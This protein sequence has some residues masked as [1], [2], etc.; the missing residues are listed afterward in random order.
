MDII[1]CVKHVPETVEEDI[2]IADDQKGIQTM[3]L[4]FDINEWDDYAIEEAVLM[5]EKLGGS[6]T[7]LTVGSEEA[8]VTLRKC[9]AKGADKAIRLTDKAFEGSDAY[10][11]AKILSKAIENLPY[12]LILTGT[13]SS[14]DGYGQVGAIL[15]TLLGIP[16]TTLARKIDVQ[17]GFAIVNRELE[18][19]LEQ[20]LEIKL[21]SVIAVQT[22][23]N[24]PRYVSIMAIRKAREKEIR[25]MGLKDLGLKEEDV[26]KIGSWLNIEEMF[27][28]PIEKEAEILTGSPD[29]IV[30]NIVKLFKDRGFV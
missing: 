6:I 19:G 5:K 22:G 25:V 15:A 7:A 11:T 13:Q 2:I 27:L 10:A 4:V 20:I 1:V 21:P 28:P 29:E 30:S 24:E 18:G 23:I 26:G 12:D 17:Q 16:H 9:L 3:D 8:D 14:D